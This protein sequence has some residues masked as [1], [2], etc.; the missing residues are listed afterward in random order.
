[1]VC[2][3]KDNDRAYADL[4]AQ[5]AKIPNLRFIRHVPFNQIDAC[6]QRAK[7]FVNTSDA[8]GFP[9]TFIQACKAGTPILSF[10]VN[11]DGFLDTYRCGLC[12]N[13]DPARLTYNLKAMLENNKYVEIGA[14]ARK[15]VEQHHDITKIASRYKDLFRQSHFSTE[16]QP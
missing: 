15:Y 8:E 12:C 4:V 6:F 9:N 14:S 1:M 13:G 16:R 10:N 2:Q 11:P 5:A 7:I 3:T